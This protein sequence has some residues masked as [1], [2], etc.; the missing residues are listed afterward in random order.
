MLHLFVPVGLL[1]INKLLR[2]TFPILNVARPAAVI[3]HVLLPMLM[4]PSQP[5]LPGQV[6][7]PSQRTT[8]PRAH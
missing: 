3:C 8:L 1:V 6:C 5:N 7:R 4:L 2:A